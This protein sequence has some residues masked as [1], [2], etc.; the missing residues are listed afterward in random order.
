[1]LSALLCAT[2]V[3][4]TI[5]AACMWPEMFA[6]QFIVETEI[7]ALDDDVTKGPGD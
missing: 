2:A 3:R 5:A 6:Y 7:T 4:S 1:M